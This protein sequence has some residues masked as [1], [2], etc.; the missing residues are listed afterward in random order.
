MEMTPRERWLALFNGDRPDRIPSDY[1][2][3][4][5]VTARLIEDLDCADEWDLWARLHVDRLKTLEPEW[6]RSHHPDDPEA[7]MWGVRYCTIGYG[8]GE[9]LEA[10]YRPLA[11][12]QNA[13]DVHAHRWPSCDDFDYSVITK[14]LEEDD[15][16]YPIHAGVYEPFLLYAYLRG[17]EQSFADLA[18]NE[19]LA[20]AIL[21][22]IFQFHHEH[23]RRIFEAGAGRIDVVK[24]AE[25]LGAQTGPLMSLPMYRRFLLPHQ[26]KMAELARSYHAHVFYHTDGAARVFLPDLVDRMGIEILNPVQWRCAGMEREG[27]VRDYGERLIF[28][29]SI[30]NQKTLPF[31]SVDEVVREVRQSIEIYHNAR[32]ICGPCHNL[33]PVTSTEK[34]VAM[35]E[36]I[37]EFGRL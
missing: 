19:E 31:G 3:T 9:Y 11:Q 20:D 5:E 8:T 14:A 29:G 2:G 21:E 18:L 27:L 28:H 36:T 35:Y 4:D 23:L 10:D 26:I 32:W 17:L 15:G 7:D 22:H 13:R 1:M 24:L 16:R 30:D 25:D 37:H 6:K 33:Q 12:A 34:I